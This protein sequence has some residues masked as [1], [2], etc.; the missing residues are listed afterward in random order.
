[1]ATPRTA[2]QQ[3]ENFRD[4]MRRL[5][6]SQGMT[7]AQLA[8]CMRE[9]GWEDFTQAVISRLENGQR[10][11]TLVES[12]AV[13][14]ALGVPVEKMLNPVANDYI[15]KEVE[16]RIR[17]FR[18]CKRELSEAIYYFQSSRDIFF[19][20]DVELTKVDQRKMFL[21]LSKYL[22]EVENSTAWDVLMSGFKDYFQDMTEQTGQQGVTLDEWVQDGLGIMPDPNFRDWVVLDA[23]ERLDSVE[24][25]SELF[26]G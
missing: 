6:I 11:L 7:Q 12:R 10:P 9:R 18:R 19:F 17:E 20:N 8:E 5:R 16:G 26:D 24:S 3:E 2:T 13:A 4:E 1:M 15:T 22:E 25:D 21:E 14:E 23:K